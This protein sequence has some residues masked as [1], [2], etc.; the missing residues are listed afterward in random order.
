MM[1]ATVMKVA[2]ERALLDSIQNAFI[3]CFNRTYRT[4]VLDAYLF[5]NLE[6]VQTITDQ[7]LID[8]NESGRMKRWATSRRRS[9]YPG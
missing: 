1:K 4:E 7:W 3:E 2:V 8:Y 9:S 5:A 6:Q